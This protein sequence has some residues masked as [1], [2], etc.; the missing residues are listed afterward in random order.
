MKIISDQKSNKSQVAFK[1]NERK[2]IRLPKRSSSSKTPKFDILELFWKHF[3]KILLTSAITLSSWVTQNVWILL[4][5]LL[6]PLIF[7][8]DAFV[9]SV[10]KAKPDAKL[11]SMHRVA[12][13]KRLVGISLSVVMIL[14]FCWPKDL[15]PL[16]V[17]I[18]SLFLMLFFY[19]VDDFF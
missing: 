14:S 19:V 4:F 3:D 8:L 7:L 11:L 18:L 2:Q 17:S 12:L 5:Y 13:K 1:Q 10:Y 16:R 6:V 15:Y 9:F